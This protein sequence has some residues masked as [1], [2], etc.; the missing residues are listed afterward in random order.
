MWHKVDHELNK[1]THRVLLKVG[2][3]GCNCNCEYQL[4]YYIDMF[5]CCNLWTQVVFL[6]KLPRRYYIF[7]C[8]VGIFYMTSHTTRRQT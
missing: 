6:R 5:H 4:I 3:L 1:H 2:S 7:L 8:V